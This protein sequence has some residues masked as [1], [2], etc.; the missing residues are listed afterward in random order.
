[1]R[2]ECDDMPTPHR[3]QTGE[4][5]DVGS[6]VG[7]HVVAVGEAPHGFRHSELVNPRAGDPG[8]D[9]LAL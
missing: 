4:V 8:T 3:Q 1:M 5:P 7:G 9:R 6:D 2:F